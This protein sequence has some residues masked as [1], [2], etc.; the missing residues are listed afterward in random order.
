MDLFHKLINLIDKNSSVIP[1]G[2]YIEMCKTIMEMHEKAHKSLQ[3]ELMEGIRL[4][5]EQEEAEFMEALHRAWSEP[6]EME[7]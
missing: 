2:D 3:A 1:E 5:R 7:T 4:M 6:V